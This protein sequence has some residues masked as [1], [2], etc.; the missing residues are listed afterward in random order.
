M[1]TCLAPAIA[2]AMPG[3]PT[4]APSSS[5][6]FPATSSGR[7]C[8]E[9]TPPG[10]DARHAGDQFQSFPLSAFSPAPFCADTCLRMRSASARPEGQGRAQKGSMS[11]RP[12]LQYQKVTLSRLAGPTSTS[13]RPCTLTRC[14]HN[15]KPTRSGLPAPAG[16]PALW[17]GSQSVR[18]WP[19]SGEASKLR[20]RRR[21]T[22]RMNQLAVLAVRWQC[23]ENLV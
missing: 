6:R 17:A 22:C 23:T 18:S 13:S 14:C 12:C 10:R 11:R 9:Q 19:V 5:T 16:T 4:P 1:T 3:A 7:L 15:L 8:S 21:A 2:A 20:G